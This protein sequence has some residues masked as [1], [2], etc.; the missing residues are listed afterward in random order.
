MKNT[1]LVDFLPNCPFKGMG[2]QL[3]V[4]MMQG[5]VESPYHWYAEST[6]PRINDTQS[7]Q[8]FVSTIRRVDVFLTPKLIRKKSEVNSPYQWY[9]ELATLR[10]NNM[11]SQ[12]L[13]VST[14]HEVDFQLWISLW[15]RIRISKNFMSSVRDLAEP[16]YTKQLKNW[17]RWYV[18]LRNRHGGLV[19]RY[20]GD[21]LG[22]TIDPR[23]IL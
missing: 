1:S 14:I 8:L 23:K 20:Y 2:S 11:R 3:P 17:S 21:F 7:R 18:L 5:F 12:R 13:S 10:I 15:I 19:Y 6:T 16:I 22:K 4:S 9:A